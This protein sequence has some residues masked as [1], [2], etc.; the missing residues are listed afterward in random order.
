MS[1]IYKYDKIR[2][3]NSILSSTS[4]GH[5]VVKDLSGNILFTT[6]SED[7]QDLL[8]WTP[9]EIST[10]AWYDSSDS[11]TLTITN[12]IV[13]Q[14]NDK[15][16]NGLHLKASSVGTSAHSLAASD[17]NGLNAIHLNGDDYYS[18]ESGG[19][20]PIPNG[21]LQAFMIAKVETVDNVSDAIISAAGSAPNWQLHAGSS[22]EFKAQVNSQ[23]GA[24]SLSS[25]DFSG[26]YHIFNAFFDW[27]NTV[28]KSYVDGNEEGSVA[29]SSPISTAQ[30]LR[31][32]TNRGFSSFPAGKMA[33]IILCHDVSDA[34]R[35][36]IEGYLAH[37][38]GLVDQLALSHP[39]KNARP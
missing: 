8:F 24:T 11:A 26:N 1:K 33:E 17:L 23:V 38:W 10:V 22:S 27:G 3:G 9:A 36:R 37:K 5:L 20:I 32:Y 14:V 28:I 34:T 30:S 16:G 4:N 18:I 21:N 7:L 12:S 25:T 2:I 13:E 39:Y 35:E 19:L 6:Q 31:V 29:Y 15:S